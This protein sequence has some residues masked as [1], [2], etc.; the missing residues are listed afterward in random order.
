MRPFLRLILLER[1][2]RIDIPERGMARSNLLSRF[3]PETLRE[4]GGERPELH[5]TEPG[6][7]GDATSQIGAVGRLRPESLGVPAVLLLH[8]GRQVLHALR[9]RAWEAMNRGL[10]PE[11]PLQFA[12]IGVRDVPWR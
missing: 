11:D 9:H 2:R 5:V 6:Q 10:F 7:R 4:Y 1:L 12:W 3:D 8:H